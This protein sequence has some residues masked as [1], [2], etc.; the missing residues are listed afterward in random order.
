MKMRMGISIKRKIVIKPSYGQAFQF[1]DGLACVQDGKLISMDSLIKREKVIKCTYDYALNFKNG[2][3]CVMKNG[4]S[5]MIDKKG[6]TITI[7]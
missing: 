5:Y 2:L 3:A 7:K 4:K 1:S 6:K